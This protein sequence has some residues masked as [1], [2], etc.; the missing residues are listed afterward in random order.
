[1]LKR[2]W[3]YLLPF[4]MLS[5]LVPAVSMA[6]PVKG[7]IQ[8]ISTKGKTIQFMNLKTK[9]VETVKYGKNTDFINAKSIKEFIVKDVILVEYQAGHPAASIKRVLVELPPEKVIKAGR[10]A[11]ILR[12]PDSAYLLVDARPPKVYKAG[13]I[14]NAVNIF[15]KKFAEGSHLLPENKNKLLIFYCGG[16]T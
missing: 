11:S 5:L 4:I 9:E 15:A 10:L 7:K 2:V 14:P 1:M 8:S 3:Y 6:D 16:P 12:G 13:H